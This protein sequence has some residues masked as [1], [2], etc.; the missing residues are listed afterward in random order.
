M[1]CTPIDKGGEHFDPSNYR[2][3]STLSSVSQVFEK[4]VCKHA[5]FILCGKIQNLK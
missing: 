3:I 4:L 5:I 2:P 1:T